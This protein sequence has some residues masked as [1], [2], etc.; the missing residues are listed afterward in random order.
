MK[1]VFDDCQY[2]DHKVEI[3]LIES[4]KSVIDFDDLSADSDKLNTN[5]FDNVKI[6][7]Y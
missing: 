5:E 7:V 3:E 1:M 2:S 4:Q 6:S